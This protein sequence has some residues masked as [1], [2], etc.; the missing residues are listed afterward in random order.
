MFKVFKTHRSG[1]G[2]DGLRAT[3]AQALTFSKP[4][5]PPGDTAP[6][7]EAALAQLERGDWPRAFA[8]MATLADAGHAPA[9]RIALLMAARGSALFG[10]VFEAPA[11]QSLRWRDISRAGATV[12]GGTGD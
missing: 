2:L 9:A 12:D 11:A 8:Q 7:F 5:P 1:H 10:G 3:L 4:A 6:L